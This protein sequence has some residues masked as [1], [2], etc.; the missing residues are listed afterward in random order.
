METDNEYS[1]TIK[2]TPD[3]TI[4]EYKGSDGTWYREY[5]YTPKENILEQMDMFREMFIEPLK[6]KEI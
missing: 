4:G 2:E 5:V 1:R 3:Y 6:N